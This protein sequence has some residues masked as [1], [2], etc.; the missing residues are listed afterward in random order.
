M[1]PSSDGKVI[2][3]IASA[4]GDRGAE[5]TAIGLGRDQRRAVAGE[6]GDA[7]DARRPKGFGH[8]HR[9]QDGGEPAGQY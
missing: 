1:T 6:A 5:A 9:R 8:G 3:T 7:L 4:H 2:T